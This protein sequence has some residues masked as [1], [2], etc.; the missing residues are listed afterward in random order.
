MLLLL[1]ALALLGSAGLGRT[2]DDPGEP[3][4][5]AMTEATRVRLLEPFRM[6][7]NREFK[8]WLEAVPEILRIARAAGDIPGVAYT[9][10]LK[11]YLFAN[12]EDPDQAATAWEGA[13]DAW[14]AVGE[15]P[16]QI[17]A[18]V[19]AALVRYRTDAEAALELLKR[20]AAVGRAERRRPLSGALKLEE[21]GR[22]FGPRGRIAEA[23]LLFQAAFDAADRASPGGR[24]AGANL[25]NLGVVARGQGNLA[26]A[27]DFLDRGLAIL[28]RCAPARPRSP[29]RWPIW[30]W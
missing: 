29:L 13:A 27:R 18:L 2:D 15:G 5:P 11:A 28:Q 21:G 6:L 24:Q 10:T 12:L 23:R 7:Q 22:T 16:N 26:E 19:N 8:E 9:Y 17:E 25:V 3:P 20:A 30:V 14:R 1:V 4:T